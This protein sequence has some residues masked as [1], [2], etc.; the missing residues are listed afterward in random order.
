M[1]KIFV[2]G[3]LWLH[4]GGSGPVVLVAVRVVAEAEVVDLRC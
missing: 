4:Y 3:G 1:A 2:T